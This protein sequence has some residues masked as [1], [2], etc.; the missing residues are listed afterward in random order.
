MPVPIRAEFVGTGISDFGRF[1][2]LAQA[3]EFFS[4]FVGISGTG[5]NPRE[6]LIFAQNAQSRT[7][8]C[9]KM[10]RDIEISISKVNGSI[11]CPTLLLFFRAL[12]FSPPH[13][14]I[15]SLQKVP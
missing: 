15:G 2:G 14:K 8:T 9:Q 4:E 5:Q 10:V 13:R 1:C 12:D 7:P 6:M 11:L 3:S